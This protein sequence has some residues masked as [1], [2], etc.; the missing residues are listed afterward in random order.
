MK[1][2]GAGLTTALSGGIPLSADSFTQTIV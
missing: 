2:S 1:R